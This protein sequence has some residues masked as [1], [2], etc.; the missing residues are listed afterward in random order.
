[1]QIVKNEKMY[2]KGV[3]FIPKYIVDALNNSGLTLDMLDRKFNSIN[4]GNKIINIDELIGDLSNYDFKTWV[5]LDSY[6]TYKLFKNIDFRKQ[7]NLSKTIFWSFIPDNNRLSEVETLNLFYSK[8]LNL[9]LSNVNNEKTYSL[10]VTDNNIFVVVHSGFT[11]MVIDNDLKGK[12]EFLTNLMNKMFDFY[13][14]EEM[15][16]NVFFKSFILSI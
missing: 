5:N 4:K 16:Q 15:L 13:G 11:D 10:E 1:M 2:N 3:V 7:D 8:N 6:L 14:E 12:K 9:L